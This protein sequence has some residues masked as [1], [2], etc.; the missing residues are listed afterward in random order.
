MLKNSSVKERSA[1][2]WGRQWLISQLSSSRKCSM[3]V[4]L[5]K[6]TPLQMT[7]KTMRSL[8]RKLLGVLPFRQFSGQRT[9]P[10]KPSNTSINVSNLHLLVFAKRRKWQSWY[11]W[12]L[13]SNRCTS[14]PTSAAHT[15]P[16]SSMRSTKAK[17]GRR[18]P[19]IISYCYYLSSA[20]LLRTHPNLSPILVTM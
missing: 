16:R 17:N 20:V 13:G 19:N 5:Q 9:M 6:W 14:A 7:R 8:V 10:C 11:G 1:R 3:L 18:I 2:R 4:L 12:S 15:G